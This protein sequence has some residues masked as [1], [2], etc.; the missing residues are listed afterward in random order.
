LRYITV[1]TVV[2]LPRDQDRAAPL[3]PSLWTAW[4]VDGMVVSAPPVSSEQRA[5]IARHVK[6][7]GEEAP[8]AVRAIRRE[9][10]KQI[11]TS[12]RG[13]QRSVQEATDAV[14]AE[15][16]RLVKEKVEEVGS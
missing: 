5:E 2:G 4:A 1:I 8:V 14:V 12:G 3:M 10:R 16:D 7:L 15:I 13:S 6:K 11:E 9:A